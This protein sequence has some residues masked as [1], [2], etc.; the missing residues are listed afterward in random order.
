M[1]SVKENFETSKLYVVKPSIVLDD[2]YRKINEEQILHKVKL[3][4]NPKDIDIA[5]ITKYRLTYK[6]VFMPRI[7]F[8]E[9]G[10]HC[11]EGDYYIGINDNDITLLSRYLFENNVE[12][13]KWTKSLEQYLISLKPYYNFDELNQ[14]STLFKESNK[15]EK[16]IVK[17]IKQKQILK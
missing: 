10:Y 17:T 6:S 12:K 1:N 11:C 14:L 8:N 7:Y 3:S 5:I 9:I 2:D 16:V 4:Q 15:D 13:T